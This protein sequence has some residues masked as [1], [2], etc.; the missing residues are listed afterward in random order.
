MLDY[1]T[2]TNFFQIGEHIS[3]YRHVHFHNFCVA[4]RSQAM[5]CRFLVIF[6]DTENKVLGKIL[7]FFA[8][9]FSL[10]L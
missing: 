3:T 9:Q 1:V 4:F 10:D 7:F 2:S 5:F 8:I 6:D